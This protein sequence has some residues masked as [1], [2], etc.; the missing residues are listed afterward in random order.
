MATNIPD[1]TEYY[2]VRI[3][4]FLDNRSIEDG[5][6]V[7]DKLTLAGL[8]AYGGKGN[9]DTDQQILSAIRYLRQRSGVLFNDIGPEIGETL[10][11][12]KAGG[13]EI[14]DTFLADVS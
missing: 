11:Q 6:S 9:K 10:K 13:Q 14:D 12:W 7:T 4:K 8:I 5:L 3:E 1:N 2:A